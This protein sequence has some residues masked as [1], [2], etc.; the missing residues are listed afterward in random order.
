MVSRKAVRKQL[1]SS[2]DNPDVQS[3]PQDGERR[4]DLIEAGIVVKIEKAAHLGLAP[5]KAAGELGLGD[6]GLAHRSV[7]KDL[8][9][10]QRGRAYHLGSLCNGLRNLLVGVNVERQGGF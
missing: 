3:L 10:A 5:S 9:L 7:K 2:G 1:R 4:F 6:A 8:S